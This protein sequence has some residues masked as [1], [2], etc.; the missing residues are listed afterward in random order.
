M[1]GEDLLESVQCGTEALPFGD[2]GGSKIE[3]IVL[4]VGNN[5]EPRSCRLRWR[6]LATDRKRGIDAGPGNIE[7]LRP[8]AK[9]PA[10]P[11]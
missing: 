9:I 4:A 1:C 8:V 6:V 3:E 11:Q 5:E 10:K 2:T 7:V